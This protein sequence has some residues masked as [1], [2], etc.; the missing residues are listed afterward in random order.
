MLDVH[1]PSH[2]PNGVRDFFL[3]L[4]TITVGLLIALGLEAGAEAIHHRHQREEADATIRQEIVQNRDA[5][6]KAQEDIGE[7]IK[8]MVKVV[9]FLEARSAGQ[10]GDP[11]G[12]SLGFHE[13]PL[14]DA[15]WRTAASTGV[16][17][18]MDYS[19]VERYSG[20]YKEQDMFEL[21]QQQALEEFLQLDSFVINGFDPSKLTKEQVTAA[22]PQARRAIAHLG[23][24]R[25]VSLG[26]IQAYDNALKQ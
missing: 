6:V 20:A 15:A 12:L 2:T 23:G 11:T 5:V 16:L 10:P 14:Q 21:M 13:G 17:S 22:L 25:D 8:N 19:H 26:A 3:H 18:Y 7:E 24:M 1:A 9:N 4:F